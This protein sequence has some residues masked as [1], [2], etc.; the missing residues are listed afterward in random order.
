MDYNAIYRDS[1]GFLLRA[2][3]ADMTPGAG[4]TLRTDCPTPSFTIHNLDDDNEAHQWIGYEWTLTVPPT[5]P[6]I[7][8]GLFCSGTYV[9]DGETTQEITGVGFTPRFLEIQ[10]RNTVSGTANDIFEAWAEV[11]D[12]DVAGMCIVHRNAASPP[13]AVGKNC[14]KSFNTDGF[15]VGDNG[16]SDHPNKDTIIYNWRA[17]G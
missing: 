3:Y 16:A 17:L 15:T 14:I 8:G 5:L 2:G 12:D 13:H 4:E 9:G 1:D 10:I 11:L 7:T 6:D